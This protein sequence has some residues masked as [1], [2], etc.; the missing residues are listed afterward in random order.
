ISTESEILTWLA[1][2]DAEIT[3]INNNKRDAD[4]GGNVNVVYCNSRNGPN[5]GGLCTV[6][7][8]GATCLHAPGT[9]CLMATAD[10]SFCS[11]GNCDG[12]CSGF[13]ACGT[14]LNNNF[15]FT[16]NTNSIVVPFV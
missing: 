4:V 15:C 3:Y 7:N 8:G 10:V 16:P 6:Y 9:Q 11:G 5:C 1:T 2:T 13:N 12:P 14:R